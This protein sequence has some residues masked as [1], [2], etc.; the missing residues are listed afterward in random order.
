MREYLLAIDTETTGLDPIKHS[1]FEI[2][3]VLFQVDK[4]NSLKSIMEKRW[5]VQWEDNEVELS[6]G[7]MAVNNYLDRRKIENIVRSDESNR[8]EFY[9]RPDDVALDFVLWCAKQRAD[10]IPIYLVGQNVSFDINFLN[11]FV[12]KHARVDKWSD[13]F[14]YRVR[15]TSTISHFLRSAGVTN[16][17]KGSLVDLAKK[18][19][20]KLERAHT[21]LDDARA[22]AGIYCAM[23]KELRSKLK[24]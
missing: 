14:S 12:A 5:W 18:Y 24:D 10:F 3:A 2:G 7:A 17:E 11:M 20:V 1:L 23:V 8:R 13:M 4:D 22:T 21:A 19:G 16:F 9:G 15:D 6:P